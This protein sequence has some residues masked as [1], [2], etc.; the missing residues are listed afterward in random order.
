[1]SNQ[2]QNST[3][4]G[5]KRT[6]EGNNSPQSSNPE[7]TLDSKTITRPAKKRFTTARDRRQHLNRRYAKVA[8]EWRE[9]NNEPGESVDRDNEPAC[10]EDTEQ[11]DK[12][13]A[14]E[15]RK[16]KRKVAA[17]VGFCGTGYQG[18]QINPNAKTIEGDLFKAFVAAG[19]VSKDNSDDP[20]KVSLMRAAR[21]DKGVHAAANVIS[22]KM[23][24]I[25]DLV[26]K[27]N[28]NLPDQLRMWGFVRVIR[29]FHAKTLCDSRIYE[30]LIPSYVFQPAPPKTSPTPH[31]AE[32]TLVNEQSQ[33]NSFR[34]PWVN[35]PVAT[36][37]EMVEK[38]TYRIPADTLYVVRQ[39]F[40]EYEGTHNFH[41]FTSGRTYHERSC[42]R[43]IVK[44]EV[45]SPKMINDTE[46]LKLKVHGQSFMLHQIRKMVAL[47]VMVVRSDTPLSLIAKTFNIEK[48]NIPRAPSL[49]LLLEQPIFKSYN[50]K[51]EA[52]GRETVD[53]AKYSQE[54]EKFKED[55]IY[56]KIYEEEFAENVF[57]NWLNAM[58]VHF[59]DSYSYL[60]PEGIIPEKA[61]AKPGE[62][63]N[64]YPQ[65][66]HDD[67]NYQRPTY[68]QQPE[69]TKW[70]SGNKLI[71]D[72]IKETQ[73]NAQDKTE[74]IEWI[75]YKQFTGV[76]YLTMGSFA[77]IYT[78]IWKGGLRQLWDEKTQQFVRHGDRK[79]V[80]KEV[81][82]ESN[83]GSDI[84]AYIEEMRLNL[85]CRHSHN[86]LPLYGIT[87]NPQSKSYMLV[88]Q[89]ASGGD[90]SRYLSTHFS[91]LTWEPKLLM[92]TEIAR[93]LKVMHSAGLIHRGLHASNIVYRGNDPTIADLGICGPL[94]KAH[95]SKYV[96]VPYTAPEVLGGAEYTQKSDIF[97]LGIL[98]W[99]ITSGDKPYS[100]MQSSEK[101]NLANYVKRGLRPSV[102]PNTPECYVKLMKKCWDDEPDNRPDIEEV[103][104]TLH[105]WVSAIKNERENRKRK[106][107]ENIR[108]KSAIDCANVGSAVGGIFLD[109]D[110]VT[111][112]RVCTDKSKSVASDEMY[113]SYDLSVL[114]LNG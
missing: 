17:L 104:E 3:P 6:N 48:I 40:R 38:R 8:E 78:A 20:K 80:L 79:V 56:S 93:G 66:D 73:L 41:N 87:Q 50:R 76:N 9:R 108:L 84:K 101:V 67:H 97:S 64:A 55:F 114:T 27:I 90:F 31:A 68:R 89:Y 25:P 11:V 106:N 71:D 16:P 112:T 92:L 23:I 30:Y 85:V 46:W 32:P 37:E 39:G 57:Q 110:E 109:A 72:L 111:K 26:Q 58:D 95:D 102:V 62:N 107:D 53:F 77:K 13:D 1:M 12:G 45:S 60:N 24:D 15:P 103:V 21:T 7:S 99:Q 88:I 82:M 100:D 10:D 54:I 33:D 47:I 113:K 44:F 34:K 94:N 83:K 18:M 98:M 51:A 28:E 52:G 96:C 81:L 69:F 75:P 105:E 70:T 59:D 29:S 74:Y 4:P 61:I 43:Y 49:G 91:S 36:P 42:D 22:L 2:S 19:A 14:K 65:E 5:H 86:I 35:I 63:R